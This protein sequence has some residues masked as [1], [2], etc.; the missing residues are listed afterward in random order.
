MKATI[1]KIGNSQGIRIPK[2]VIEQCKFGREVVLSVEDG[3]L[4]VAPKRR[5]RDGWDADAFK[6]AAAGDD[7]L[8][9]GDFPNEFDEKE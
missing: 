9:L 4:V 5:P 6:C 7:G 1:V 3:R 2:T 8:L